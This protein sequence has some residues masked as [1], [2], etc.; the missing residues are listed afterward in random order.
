VI[1]LSADEIAAWRAAVAPVWEQF[2]DVIGP[3]LIEAAQS[4]G[5]D[6]R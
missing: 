3:D 1:T 5:S 4:V 2:A 6:A